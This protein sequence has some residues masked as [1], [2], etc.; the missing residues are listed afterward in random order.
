MQSTP[1]VTAI[2]AWLDEVAVR[3]PSLPGGPL[4][5][6]V[7]YALNQWSTL[8]HFLDDGRI[9]EISNNGC[10][11]AL[12]APVIGRK[13]WYFFGSEEGAAA[14]VI[15]MSLVQ[16]C[17]EHGINPLLYLRDV[18]HLISATPQSRI[19]ELT[20]RG[21]IAMGAEIE[22]RQRSKDAIADV[23]ANLSF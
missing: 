14:G 5:V 23:V 19:G 7:T 18:L 9:R 16:S 2:K 20:P 6:G 1:I 4:M 11:R 8:T 17:R 3:P 21:W 22:R 15:M 12:R 10:E 13:N